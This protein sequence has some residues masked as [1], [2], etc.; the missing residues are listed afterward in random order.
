MFHQPPLLI[1]R[2]SITLKTDNIIITGDLNA[3]HT[4]F[5]C[6]KTDTWRLE[7]NTVLYNAI[8][9]LLKTANPHTDTKTNTS[10]NRLCNRFTG[11]L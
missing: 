3:K 11:Y 9:S 10:D 6:T 7:L 1:P 2:Y 5:N 4:N 8:S